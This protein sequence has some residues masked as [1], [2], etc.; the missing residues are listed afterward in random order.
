MQAYIYRLHIYKQQNLV[1]LHNILSI[2]DA[3]SNAAVL[4]FDLSAAFGTVNH[5]LLL[6]KLSAE[7]GFSDVALEWFSTY[8]NNMSYFV[9]SAGCTSHTVDVKSGVP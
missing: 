3:K 9:K 1:K 2:L 7:C 4:L 8:L 5:D 6:S